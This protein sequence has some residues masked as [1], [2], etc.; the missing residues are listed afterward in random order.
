MSSIPA[1]YISTLAENRQ[2]SLAL[3]GATTIR[4][5]YSRQDS[6]AHSG[7]TTYRPPYLPLIVDTYLKPS[8]FPS[9]RA[10]DGS[11]L[12]DKVSS[13]QSEKTSLSYAPLD[14][15]SY[16]S[17]SINQFH[18][19]ISDPRPPYPPPV[20]KNESRL[21]PRHFLLLML[22]PLAVP[23]QLLFTATGA[24]AFLITSLMD[25]IFR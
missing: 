6:L 8:L 10:P 22:L 14:T 3:S 25:K 11:S 18:N 23:A 20:T 7:V 19:L 17:S 13:Q 21:P 5:P 1:N 24:I 16:Y 2:D 9:E 4:P 15:P 12:S